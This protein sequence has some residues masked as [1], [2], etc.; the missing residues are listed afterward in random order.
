MTYAGIA[1]GYR[2]GGFNTSYL[3]N[4]DIHFDPEFSWNYEVGL[5]TSWFDNQLI[6]NTALFYIDLQDQQVLQLLPSTQT[7]I[8]NAG[9]SR[10]KGLEMELKALLSRGLTLEAGFGY[11]DAEY[12]DYEDS[13][14]G[15]DYSGNATVLAPEYTYNLAIEYRRPLTGKW[16]FFLRPELI[17]IGSFYW[18]DANTLKQNAYQMVNLNIGFEREQFDLVFW[19]RNL[20]DEHYEAIAFEFPGSDP[21]AQSGAPVTFGVTFRLRF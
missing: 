10:S 4:S 20:F 18:N 13:L 6:F 2:S 1:R 12:T 3:K 8:R 14:A 17:G 16:D 9:K 7:V 15:T 11:T 19:T 5:K 21:V